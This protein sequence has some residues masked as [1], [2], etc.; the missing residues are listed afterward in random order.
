MDITPILNAAKAHQWVLFAALITGGLIAASKQGWLSTW[1]ASKLTPTTTPYVA[2]VT[3]VL[4]IWVSDVTTGKTWQ[5]AVVDALTNGLIAG[6]SA[7]AG[8]Q[9][10][11]ESLRKGKEIVPP[12]DA[13]GLLRIAK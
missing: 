7:I 6:L 9:L 8:H 11:I 5:A 12:T 4:T 13:V 2:L 3:G 1:I 10:V